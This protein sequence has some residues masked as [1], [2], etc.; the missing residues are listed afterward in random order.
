MAA[1][2]APAPRVYSSEVL[3]VVCRVVWCTEEAETQLTRAVAEH[4]ALLPAA[5]AC[6]ASASQ[7]GT[8]LGSLPLWAKWKKQSGKN[9]QQ[10]LSTDATQLISMVNVGKAEKNIMLNAQIGDMTLSLLADSCEALW[11]PARGKTAWAKCELARTI[12]HQQFCYPD[13]VGVFKWVLD[14]KQTAGLHGEGMATES[15]CAAT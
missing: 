3:K 5:A 9:L 7:L 11:R 8:Q 15:P 14:E 2:G 4:L 1:D 10:L 13:S 12:V 6:T